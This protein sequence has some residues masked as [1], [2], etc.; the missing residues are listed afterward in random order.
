MSDTVEKLPKCPTCEEPLT[1]IW[2]ADKYHITWQ[3]GHWVKEEEASR[4][5]C[6]KCNNELDH[7]DIEDIMR[8][9]GLL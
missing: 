9:V 3:D 7:D 4:L 1:D 5:I 8:A 6:G 2:G